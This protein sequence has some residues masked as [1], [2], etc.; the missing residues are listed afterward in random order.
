MTESEL[1][2]PPEG[3]GIGDEPVAP[4]NRDVELEQ[5]RLEVEQLRSQQPGTTKARRRPSIPWRRISRWTLLVVGGLLAILSVL[6]IWVRD[7]LLD[8]DTWVSTMAPVAASP[9]V[10]SAIAN[11]VTTQLFEKADLQTTVKNNLPPSAAFLATPLTNQLRSFTNDAAKRL[12]ASNQF[13]SLWQDI[14]R[15]AHAA[16][17]VVLT[18]QQRGRVSF[19][20]GKVT[21]DLSSVT[22]SLENRLGS[23][24]IS[25]LQNVSLGNGQVTLVNSPNLAKAQTAIRV[26]KGIAF[27]FPVVALGCLAGATFLSQDRRR[28]LLV[29]ALGLAVSMVVLLALL[30]ILRNIYLDE[31][32]GPRLP[33]DA[34]GDIYNAIVQF[35]RQ[36]AEVVFAAGVIVAAGAAL[37]G[38]SRVA[39]GIRR[40]FRGG[41]DGLTET[42]QARGWD[43][44]PAGIWIGEH[45][46]GLRVGILVG[47]FLVLLLWSQPTAWVVLGLALIVALLLILVEVLDRTPQERVP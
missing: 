45:R 40:I 14:N 41:L 3:G 21:L 27:L 19:S 16:V 4:S 18:G 26:M 44:G 39:V 42:T 32:V 22:T 28:G 9:A 20:D 10:Q 36:S 30:A 23:A 35:V 12:I 24:G 47:A 38:P 33:S 43:L 7:T 29:A 8:T 13:Q 15:R 6:M 46:N 2:R 34:A 1:G 17:V 31:V 11:D 37:A 5:L 25:A